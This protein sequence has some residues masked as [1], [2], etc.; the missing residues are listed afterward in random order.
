MTVRAARG[1]GAEEL[2]GA[3]TVPLDGDSPAAQA[4]RKGEGL[5]PSARTFR[6]Q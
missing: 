6:T 5:T 2:I 1:E 4:L 3:S